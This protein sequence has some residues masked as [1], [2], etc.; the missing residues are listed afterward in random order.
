VKELRAREL[1]GFSVDAKFTFTE[2]KSA[3]RKQSLL[4]HPDTGGSGEAFQELQAA[5]STLEGHVSATGASG[6]DKA[7]S[8][9]D[10]TPLVELGHGYPLTTS[11]RTCETCQGRGYQEFTKTVGYET[12]TCEK[13]GGGGLVRY[14]CRKCGGDG[15]YKHPK[16]GKVSGE[17]YLCKGTGWF[18]PRKKKQYS[19]R[20]A[21]DFLRRARYIP[22]TDKVGQT[23]NA[24]DGHGTVEVPKKDIRKIYNKCTKCAGVGEIEMRNPVIPRGFLAA[25]EGNS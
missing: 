10:G 18:Y 15:K 25:K 3:F 1:L 24:C 7:L 19:A 21:F 23:C 16:T 2:L 22:G 17:C 9:V 11:A 5:F 8:T 12:A 20:S 6:T 14:P 4:A 13:C